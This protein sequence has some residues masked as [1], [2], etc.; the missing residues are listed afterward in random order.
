MALALKLKAHVTFLD[1]VAAITGVARAK[2]AFTRDESHWLE[3]R[4]Q[5][6]LLLGRERIQRRGKPHALILSACVPI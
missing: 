5:N 4:G 3:A 6:G 1:Q 2:N